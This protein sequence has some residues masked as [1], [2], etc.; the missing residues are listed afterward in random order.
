M[1]RPEVIDLSQ[2][3]QSHLGQLARWYL[4][5]DLRTLWPD[6]SGMSVLGLGYATPLLRPFL[7]EAERVVAAMPASQGV[8]HWPRD[9][10]NHV[11]L[12]DEF[13][14]PL[15]EAAF[16]R[17]V[18]AHCLETSESTAALLREV[19]RCLAPGGR[20][21]FIVPN[22]TGL[23]IRAEHTPFAHGQPYTKGQLVRLLGAHMFQ[24]DQVMTSLNIPPSR[25]R[26]LMRANQLFDRLGRQFWPRVGGAVMAEAS[27]QIYAM[28]PARRSRLPRALIR[29]VI[30][31]VRP[32][33]QTRSQRRA[34]G[35]GESS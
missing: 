35:A 31:T 33:G 4:R 3:Y 17:I 27:K 11:L 23:W 1:W 30:G 2:F 18:V 29:P 19:W 14:L 7:N 8:H 6:V 32:V 34:S 28:P 24:A 25:W 12:C 20:A 13:D 16:D 5:R 21:V 15:P 10:Q 26:F 22:R 9:G